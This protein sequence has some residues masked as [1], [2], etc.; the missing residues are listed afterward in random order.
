MKPLA[1]AF[2]FP[3]SDSRARLLRVTTDISVSKR[4][5]MVAILTS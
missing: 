5:D 4:S 1:A 3:I 2:S